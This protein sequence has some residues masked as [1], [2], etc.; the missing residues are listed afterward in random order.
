MFWEN[1][2]NQ[3]YYIS[4]ESHISE[5]ALRSVKQVGYNIRCHLT[6]DFSKDMLPSSI[7]TIWPLAVNCD[8]EKDRP[9]RQNQQGVRTYIHFN[10]R[11]RFIFTGKHRWETLWSTRPRYSD[12]TSARRGGTFHASDAPVERWES[13]CTFKFQFFWPVWFKLMLLKGSKTS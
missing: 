13:W 12:P 1:N 4:P 7:C 8:L 6:L 5:W 2:T 11:N 3:R 10:D 9:Y